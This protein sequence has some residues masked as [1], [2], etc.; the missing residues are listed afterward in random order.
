[1]T[2]CIL[3]G[4]INCKYGDG[5]HYF[6]TTLWFFKIFFSVNDNSWHCNLY[7]YFW[8]QCCECILLSTRVRILCQHILFTKAKIF[9]VLTPC[10]NTESRPSSLNSSPFNL[11]R[12]LLSLFLHF[13]SKTIEKH[14]SRFGFDKKWSQWIFGIFLV[15]VWHRLAHIHTVRIGTYGNFS[16]NSAPEVW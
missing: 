3:T 10:V 14:R 15:V 8:Q 7:G 4:F 16:R 12:F 2:L 1:M 5:I 6:E 9:I 11:T 13:I